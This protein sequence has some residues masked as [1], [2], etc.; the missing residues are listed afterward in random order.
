LNEQLLAQ[1]LGGYLIEA[2]TLARQEAVFKEA[3]TAFDR[4]LAVQFSAAHDM[5]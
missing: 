3:A 4:V 1:P 5:G 2:P